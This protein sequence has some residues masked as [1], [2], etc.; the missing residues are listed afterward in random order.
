M[1]TGLRISLHSHATLEFNYQGFRLVCD[2]WL[3]G[4]AFFGA[5]RHYPTPLIKASDLRPNAIWISHEH[6]DHCHEKTLRALDKDIPVFIPPFP[7]RRLEKKLD[8]LGFKDIRPME[9]GRRLEIAKDFYITV[10]EPGSLWNDSQLLLEIGGFRILNI[11][12]AGLN[13]RIQSKVGRVDCLCAAFSP[14][15][16]G[17]PATYTHLSREE[18]LDIY[19]R[20]G[21]AMLDMLLEACKSYGARYMLPFASH[22]VLNH[23][24]KVEYLGVVKKNTLDC[25]K[26][27]FEGSGVEVIGLLAGDSWEN[28]GLRLLQREANLYDPPVI[29]KAL[30]EGFN[31]E[32]FNLSYP[33][34]EAYAFRREEVLAYLDKLNL[35]PQIAFCENLTA[36]IYPDSKASLAIYFEISR[37]QLRIL[38]SLQSANLTINIPSELLMYI[39][40][41]NESWDEVTIGYWCEFSRHP[42]VY[43]PEF[44]RLLQAPYFLRFYENAK[45]TK[46][47]NTRDIE[48]LRKM[49]V[50]HLLEELGDMG[51]RILARYGLYC[52]SCEKAPMESL[53]EAALA[54]GLSEIQK[55]RLLGELS[56]HLSRLSLCKKA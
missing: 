50:A 40:R 24:S 36:A 7:N 21:E 55:N 43:H 46:S 15:A 44:W 56:A 12:D 10:Y 17:Y 48:S 45:T 9:F 27:R 14:G 41:H 47:K 51:S 31:E 53:E 19:K 3:E 32:E 37:G 4:S 16:S 28:S 34:K 49:A 1:P 30:H 13:H 39:C 2:P 42:D 33:D 52:L 11:N 18:K 5:W 35:V 29:L 38:P 22:F 26:R 8:L 25:V 54:H 6:S 23:P 20:S